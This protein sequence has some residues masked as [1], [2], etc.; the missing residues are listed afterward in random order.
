MAVPKLKCLGK[1]P[2]V[3]FDDRRESHDAFR[4]SGDIEKPGAIEKID[5]PFHLHKIIFQLE[6]FCHRQVLMLQGDVQ[7]SNIIK[8]S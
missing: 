5:F 2:I 1:C 4:V 3:I 8:S 7:Y 6:R